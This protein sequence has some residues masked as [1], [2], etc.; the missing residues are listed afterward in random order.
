MDTT[1]M[2]SREDLD[3]MLQWQEKNSVKTQ[4]YLRDYTILLLLGDAGLRIGELVQLVVSDV[5]GDYELVRSLDVRKE[6][7]KYKIPRVI[8]LSKR[9]RGSLHQYL[10]ELAPGI[11]DRNRFLFPARSGH[12][13]H[14]SERQIQNI[15]ERISL[16]ALGKKVHP[17]M[18]RHGFATFLMR[19]TPL[20]VV[21]RLLGHKNLS[22]TQAY[23][24][25]DSKDL[26]DAIDSL[27]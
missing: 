4:A 19:T 5:L 22:S 23:V 14:L 16:P 7:A 2:V 11:D 18:L 24:H 13:G 17:H 25:P 27:G 8:P 12:S 15:V 1:K 26:F 10:R 6:I 3:S 20:P 21:Q 9:L